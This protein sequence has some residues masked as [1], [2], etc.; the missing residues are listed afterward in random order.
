[1]IGG[2]I[3]VAVVGTG[4]WAREMHLP[5]FAK[6]PDVEVIGVA[7][8]NPRNARAVADVFGIERATGD[9]RQLLDDPRV[10][11]VDVLTPNDLHAEVS[12]AAVEAGRHVIC[13][14]PL[15][16]TL[17]EGRTMVDAASRAG[18]RLF[19][20]ENVPFIPAV[21]RAIAITAAGGIGPVIRVKACEGIDEPHAAWFHERERSGGGA[22]IDMAVHSIAFCNAFAGAPL[23][24]V[25]AETGTFARDRGRDAVEDTAVLTLR[26]D[27][28]VI[29]QCED[30][31]TLAGAMDSRFEV[32]GLD[33][34]ILID[35][36]HR[37]PLQ[38][39]SRDGYELGGRATGPGW[40][41]PSAIDGDIGDGHLAMLRHFVDCLR[42]G[43]PA[44]S[45]ALVGLEI[46]A[47]VAAANRSAM[48]G[49]R[50]PV[51]P[52]TREEP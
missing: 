38:V 15:A 18:V 47:A 30:S 13:I 35:N 25:Y 7:A 1:M 21:E 5:A 6:L 11:V 20:A 19:Y 46:L 48:S 27:N 45:D 32:F 8:A 37:Q 10:D 42:S 36:L 34:R 44:R 39:V 3:G 52:F 22:I 49:R 40:S 12:I 41:Y 26:Y 50:E 16:R 24:A 17:D 2:R 33:G 29:G 31:W 4:F 14:K 51:A 9:Y 23:R 28:D 43:A